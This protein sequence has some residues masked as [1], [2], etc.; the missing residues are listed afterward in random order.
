MWWWWWRR[1]RR[2]RRRRLVYFSYMSGMSGVMGTYTQ[3]KT[4]PT[5]ITVIRLLYLI[6]RIQWQTFCHSWIFMRVETELTIAGL[7]TATDKSTQREK[8]RQG[9]TDIDRYR[10]PHRLWPIL[11]D[12][13]T[14]TYMYRLFS[15]R[16]RR[17]GWDGGWEGDGGKGMTNEK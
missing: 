6:Q 14:C 9:H 8:Q 12:R 1:W 17:I 2:R 4:P 15:N 10:Q 3:T 13:E 7:K 11:T 16:W 5:T